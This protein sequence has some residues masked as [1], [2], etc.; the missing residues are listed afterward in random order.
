M[1]T[2]NDETAYFSPDETNEP[3]TSETVNSEMES[4]VVDPERDNFQV[5]LESD[6]TSAQERIF[7]FSNKL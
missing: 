6:I 7:D 1:N 5:E 2:E 4:V 3:I